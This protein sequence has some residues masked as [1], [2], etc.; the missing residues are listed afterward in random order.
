M[1]G[2]CPLTL[3]LSPPGRGDAAERLRPSSLSP[4]GEG[5]GEG[6]LSSGP[7]LEEPPQAEFTNSGRLGIAKAQIQ[8]AYIV[9]ESDDGIV[10]V[11]QHAAHERIVYEKLKAALEAGG[12]ARQLLLIPEIVEMDETDAA[13]ILCHSAAMEASG[14]VIEGLSLIHI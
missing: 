4:R 10:L 1:G 9:A 14:L 5:W 2:K 7:G 12:I 3:S 6:A 8:S 13:L 11:D